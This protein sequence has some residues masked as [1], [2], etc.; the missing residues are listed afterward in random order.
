LH[1][2]LDKIVAD[3][4]HRVSAT[5]AGKRLLLTVALRFADTLLARAA[6]RTLTNVG[7]YSAQ[8]RSP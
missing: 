1:D 7:P 4:T 5:E 8:I 3:H 2:E 6:A